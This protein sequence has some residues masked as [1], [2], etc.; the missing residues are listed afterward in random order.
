MALEP[1]FDMKAFGLIL[2]E[3]KGILRLEWPPSEVSMAKI[4][5]SWEKIVGND[6][7]LHLKIEPMITVKGPSEDLKESI[8]QV[9][10]SPS[11]SDASVVV[12]HLRRG[13]CY[14]IQMYTVTSSGIVSSNRFEEHIRITA[15]IVNLAVD[16]IT[17]NT[18]VLKILVTTNQEKGFDVS[19]DISDCMLNVV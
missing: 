4:K 17:K 18:A 10:T 12:D 15:P 13:A 16:Q 1:G 6:S 11:K 2:A 3:N 19:S 7:Q 8:R 5:D 14:R 9:E